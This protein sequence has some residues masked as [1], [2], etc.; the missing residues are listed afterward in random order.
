MLHVFTLDFTTMAHSIH[1]AVKTKAEKNPEII[2][3]GNWIEWKAVVIIMSVFEDCVFSSVWYKDNLC[4]E[5]IS[6]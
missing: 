6:N 3:Y 5:T 1:L 4:G 2:K